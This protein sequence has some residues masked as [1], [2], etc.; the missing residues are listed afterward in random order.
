MRCQ[1]A[2]SPIAAGGRPLAQMLAGAQS[3]SKL[4]PATAKALDLWIR[5]IE[6]VLHRIL[7]ESALASILDLSGLARCIAAA[8]IGFELYDGVDPA[9]A[10]QAMAA[11]AQLGALIDV[12]EGLGPAARRLIRGKLRRAE[13]MP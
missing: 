4:G 6:S 5:E 13:A 3:E 1:P 8:F 11:I 10:S 12:V 2:V 7:A 9:G